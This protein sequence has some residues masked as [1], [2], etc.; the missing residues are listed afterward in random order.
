M[1]IDGVVAGHPPCVLDLEA[2]GSA[3]VEA[4]EAA[5]ESLGERQ[6]RPHRLRDLGWRRRSRRT[7]TK[8]PASA[9]T[10]CSAMVSPALSCASAVDA[11]RC[12]VTTTR[13]ELEQ[14]RVG[15]GLRGEHVEGGAADPAR[16][17]PRRRGPPR[18]RCRRGPALTIRSA[19]LGLGQQLGRRSGP[20]VSGVFG[21]WM[22]R[23]SD[24]AT[25]SSSGERARRRSAGPGRASRT[26]RR[27]HSRMPKA[28]ARWATSTPIRPRP[29]I[30]SVL[31]W[32]STPSHFERFHF[33]ATRA[34]VGLGDVA[35][36]GEQQRHGVLGRR[37]DV[38]LRRV[39]DHHAAAGGRLD[40]D[41][42]EPDA[43]PPHHDEV[44]AGLEHLGGDLRGRPH[45]QRVRAP[46][47][48]E[49]RP[50]ARGRAAR[51]PRWPASRSASRPRSASFSVTR[52]RG[53]VARRLPVREAGRRTNSLAD[54]A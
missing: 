43:G 33:P 28:S 37:Q 17:A 51:R 1:R 6:E 12:G 14:R 8:S 47:R 15:G 54:A 9:R 36:L 39:D 27:R 53:H 30:P 2:F 38:R 7:G 50:R 21:R 48:A 22:V 31:P 42:V 32:S 26:G 44:G 16:R 49:Q 46:H 4:G 25:S 20:T 29:T 19:G 3:V 41:V 34:R 40:V 35:R 24:V 10:T 5:A 52:T 11:P 23:K 13:G 18:R 45:D